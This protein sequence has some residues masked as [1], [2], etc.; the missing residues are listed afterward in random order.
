[1]TT[2]FEN[3][4]S[5]ATEHAVLS[6]MRRAWGLD[7]F[8]RLPEFEAADYAIEKRD[9]EQMVVEVKGRTRKYLDSLSVE[10]AEKKIRALED[11]AQRY[12]VKGVLVFVMLV[13]RS[14]WWIEVEK[15]RRVETRYIGGR[16]PRPGSA[17]DQ[18]VMV[19]IP[20]AALTG[21]SGEWLDGGV[22][23]AAIAWNIEHRNG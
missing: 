3:E 19:A 9:G 7:R 4:T 2:T 20:I 12:G 23:D 13:D 16:K 1:M 10:I 5:K 22:A 8:R 21:F 11:L 14:V 17:N 15:V 6:I 18:E